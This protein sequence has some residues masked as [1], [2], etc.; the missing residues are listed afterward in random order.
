M[1][2]RGTPSGLDPAI[3]HRDVYVEASAEHLQKMLHRADVK[4]FTFYS[5]E[6]ESLGGEDQHPYPLDYFTAA[7]AL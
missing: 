6:P 1:A 5:D 2:D 7:V 3:T 4:Q